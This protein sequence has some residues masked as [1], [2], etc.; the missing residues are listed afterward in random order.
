MLGEAQSAGLGSLVSEVL[1]AVL[2]ALP[3]LLGGS[4]SLLVDDG[5]DL[6]N[7]LS[8]NLK[9]KTHSQFRQEVNIYHH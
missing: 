7:A 5:Q 3:D 8:H 9:L 6:G 2:L 4:S 1:G